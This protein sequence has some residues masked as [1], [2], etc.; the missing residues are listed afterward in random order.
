MS[1]PAYSKHSERFTFYYVNGFKSIFQVYLS[2]SVCL[3]VCFF[4][5]QTHRTTGLFNNT[6]RNFG[7]SNYKMGGSTFEKLF[8]WKQLA[9]FNDSKEC[10]KFRRDVI[11]LRPTMFDRNIQMKICVYMATRST[12]RYSIMKLGTK[13]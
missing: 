9:I 6:L 2:M 12:F 4:C 5:V 10:G 8:I 1:R 3:S 13:Y 11:G 7:Q